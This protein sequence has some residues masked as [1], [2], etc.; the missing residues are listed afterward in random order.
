VGVAEG[1]WLPVYLHILGFK[2]EVLPHKAPGVEEMSAKAF[3]L[4]EVLVPFDP[5][6]CGHLPTSLLNASSYALEKLRGVF[7][8]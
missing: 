1:I 4:R 7:Q 2:P 5:H 6:A 8:G 3:A